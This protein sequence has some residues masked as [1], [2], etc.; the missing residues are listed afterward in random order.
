MDRS[1][2]TIL[3]VR[4]PHGA[5]PWACLIFPAGLQAQDPGSLPTPTA[6]RTHKFLPQTSSQGQ[7]RNCS[8]FGNLDEHRK[9]NQTSGGPVPLSQT[10]D[11]F[12]SCL[13]SPKPWDSTRLEV[14]RERGNPG[15]S[16]EQTSTRLPGHASGAPLPWQQ[17]EGGPEHPGTRTVVCRGASAV[18][19]MDLWIPKESLGTGLTMQADWFP[20]TSLP[21]LTPQSCTTGK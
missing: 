21:L 4:Q 9:D 12:H 15:L 10:V 17:R 11:S 8:L 1:H 5:E 14:E 2:F 6:N 20:H 13:P 19:G 3:A 16:W 18:Y 7:G